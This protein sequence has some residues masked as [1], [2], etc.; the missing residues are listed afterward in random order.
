MKGEF[1][2]TR[3]TINDPYIPAPKFREILKQRKIDVPESKFLR[4]PLQ[5]DD[6]NGT[7]AK[8]LYKGVAKNIIGNSDIKGSSPPFDRVIFKNDAFQYKPRD[9]DLMDYSDVN[10]STS[11][12]RMMQYDSVR[13]LK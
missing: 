8:P 10:I 12:K 5:I 2:P 11:H 7:R 3:G 9:Y 4:D 6:I 13:D 1:S